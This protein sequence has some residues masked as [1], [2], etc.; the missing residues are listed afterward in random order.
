MHL[1]DGAMEEQSD[2][3]DEIQQDVS[4]F[5]L[6]PNNVGQCKRSLRIYPTIRWCSPRKKAKLKKILH[7]NCEL[8]ERESKEE[9]NKCKYDKNKAHL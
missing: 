1:Q 8:I 4:I 9:E 2:E 5:L 7:Y 6:N 3:L